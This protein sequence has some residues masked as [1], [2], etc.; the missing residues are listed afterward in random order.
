[1]ITV[2]Y[3]FENFVWPLAYFYPRYVEEEGVHMS[4]VMINIGTTI[5]KWAYFLFF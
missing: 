1:M 5:S 3:S 2:M 4:L